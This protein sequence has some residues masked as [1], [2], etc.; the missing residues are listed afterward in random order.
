MST[1][2]HAEEPSHSLNNTLQMETHGCLVG[3]LIIGVVWLQAEASWLHFLTLISEKR[4]W[5]SSRRSTESAGSL[6]SRPFTSFII[7]GLYFTLIPGFSAS[8]CFNAFHPPPPAHPPLF[9][10][11]S[12]PRS[13]KKKK[14]EKKL[15]LPEADNRRNC[16]LMQQ[17]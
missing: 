6:L 3:R 14:K 11:H 16:K 5:P 15:N 8:V 13:G 12:P 17:S 10:H 2:S 1:R 7:L 4:V 9:I